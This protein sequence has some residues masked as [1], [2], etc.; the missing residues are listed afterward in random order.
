MNC[1]KYDDNGAFIKKKEISS[2]LHPH[3]V[4]YLKISSNYF[5]KAHI[6]M[7]CLPSFSR[8]KAKAYERVKVMNGD[9]IY[10]ICLI[11]FCI[12]IANQQLFMVILLM[13]FS[14]MFINT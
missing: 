2:Q 6:N 5:R 9:I 7:K 4:L 11:Y 14:F 12:R 13:M 1:Y 8:N 10:Y 3:T